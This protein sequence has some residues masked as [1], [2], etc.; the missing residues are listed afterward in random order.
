[1]F[2]SAKR[3]DI[4]FGTRDQVSFADL[5]TVIAAGDE[6]G[7][8]WRLVDRKNGEFSSST[9]C[10]KLAGANEL[11]SPRRHATYIQ[12]HPLRRRTCGVRAVLR[13]WMETI[14]FLFS[15]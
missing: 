13:K 2:H 4:S 8:E 10:K 12:L 11:V 6:D 3:G 5:T 15:P 1:M 9:L 14:A 7:T